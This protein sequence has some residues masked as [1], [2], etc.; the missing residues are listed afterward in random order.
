M[1]KA[2]T[3]ALIISRIRATLRRLSMQ[4][5][6]A[7]EA[8][9]RVRR[10][11]SGPNPRQRFEYRCAHCNQWFPEKGVQVDHKI[12]AGA[13][14]S[15][16]DV[17]PFAQRLLFCN[18]NDLEVLCKQDHQ[19]KTNRERAERKARHEHHRPPTV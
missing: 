11:Y 19:V 12:P 18:I 17:G 4:M 3:E 14:K 7:R 6:A 8:K 5:P 9:L 2:W 13:M 10:A 1:A 16:D 15:F